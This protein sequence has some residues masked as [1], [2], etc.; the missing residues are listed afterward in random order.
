MRQALGENIWHYL[1]YLL[2]DERSVNL[3]NDIAHGWIA[4][5]ACDRLKT[6]MIIFTVL[7]LTGLHR[8]P[9]PAEESSDT[10]ESEDNHT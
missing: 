3:R 8:T 10:N 1:Y 5:L 9:E 2:V 6:Q 7:L 4:A